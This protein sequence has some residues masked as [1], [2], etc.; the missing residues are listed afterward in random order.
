VKY[1]GLIWA[2]LWR[3]PKR[4]WFTVISIA[5]A[6]LLFAVLIGFN[7]VL[8]SGL[9]KLNN[10][11]FVTSKYAQEQLPLGY[12]SRV[13][14]TP[15]VTG[16]SYMAYFGGYFKDRRFG[17]PVYATDVTKTFHIYRSLLDI[18]ED[19]LQ[20][21]R[22]NRTGAVVAERLANLYGWKVGDR[23]SFG[24]SIWTKKDGGNDYPVDIVGL[25]KS[26]DGSTE[27][28]SGAVF[29]NYEY[30]NESRVF[31]RDWVQFFIAEIADPK[32]STDVTNAIDAKFA[33]SSSETHTM[34]E[35][36]LLESQMATLSDLELLINVIV[37]AAFFSL[38]FVTASTM[39]Q[40]VRER[41]PEFA[42][43]K[44]LGF[45]DAAVFGMVLAEALLLCL[46]AAVV[47][48]LAARLVF[49]IAGNIFNESGIPWIVI[50]QSFGI[51][52]A[53][54]LL[55]SALPALRA[56]RLTIIE[57]LALRR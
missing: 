35:Q 27:G 33:N 51:A 49:L 15:G 11:L 54:A 8:D 1:F 3:R 36:A 41:R 44:T 32:L 6:F 17:V 13:E 18:P 23:I 21:M 56:G 25:F 5:V 48:L 9:S 24:S 26:K 7:V 57:S 22:E 4:T 29:I 19:T 46:F 53:L 34:T 39:T 12:L 47:G 14:E 40:S 52:G 2:Q 10:R 16:V 31:L 45:S 20:K 50:L 28:F 37:A 43:L 38:L 55:S 42:M 30:L